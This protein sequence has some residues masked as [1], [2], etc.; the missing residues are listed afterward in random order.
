[1]FCVIL[2]IFL[3]LT[4]SLHFENEDFVSCGIVTQGRTTNISLNRKIL[5][6]WLSRIGYQSRTGIFQSVILHKNVLILEITRLLL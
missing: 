2:A 3:T 6:S 1:M 4:G 5:A